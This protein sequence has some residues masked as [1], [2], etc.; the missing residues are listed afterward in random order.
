MQEIIS[1][2]KTV[3]LSE[4]QI[5][6]KIQELGKQISKDYENQELV[7]VCVLRGAALF[8]ADLAREISLPLRFEFL[9]TSSYNDSTEPSKNIKF[10]R[11]GSGYIK[12]KDVLI[13]E[14]IID[15]GQTLTFLVQHLQTLN[16]KSIKICTLLD[17]PS[18]RQV[19]VNID[20]S[21]FEIPN[22][23]VVGYGLDYAQMYRNLPYIAI[24]ETTSDK[25]MHPSVP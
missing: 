11:S 4:E 13:V 22:V 18:R 20:Y 24:L 14:D 12:D 5:R 3:L 23:F 9:Q 6:N 17:K 19:S 1:C 25:V 2:P 16:P 15:S 10:I 21:G 8:F 7:L